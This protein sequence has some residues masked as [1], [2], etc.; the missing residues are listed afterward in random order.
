MP[1][2]KERLETMIAAAKGIEQQYTTVTRT[3]HQL[4]SRAR[5]SL[6]DGRFDDARKEILLVENYC[7]TPEASIILHLREIDKEENWMK[8]THARN[9]AAK[10]RQH[11]IRRA[12]GIQPQKY[13]HEAQEMGRQIKQ[14]HLAQEALAKGE[15]L[16]TEIS[17]TALHNVGLKE[18]DQLYYGSYE[19]Y[20][21]AQ[22][23]MGLEPEPDKYANKTKYRPPI[24]QVN[25]PREEAFAVAQRAS[26]EGHEVSTTFD[27]VGRRVWKCSGCAEIF[28]TPAQALEHS[29]E[30]E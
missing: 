24:E 15:E 21:E 10:K 26:T 8:L 27:D 14:M 30:M 4:A 28:Y 16:T 3:F 6:D 11:R 25:I 19:K 20:C 13:G 22:I 12:R 17:Q 23:A 2:T 1:I 7:L 29:K 5:Q 9:E 18:T